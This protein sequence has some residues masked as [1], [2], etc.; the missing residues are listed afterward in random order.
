M[1]AFD[2]RLSGVDE[3]LDR[4]DVDPAL[5]RDVLAQL[6]RVNRWLGGTRAL[7]LEF[8]R[9]LRLIDRSDIRLL[10]VGCGVGDLPAAL[11]EAGKDVGVKVDPVGVD[12]H[13][14]VLEVANRRGVRPVLGS[15]LRLPFADRSFDVVTA[16]MVLHHFEGEQLATVLRECCRVGRYA[17]IVNDLYRHP[18]A[19]A[20]WLAWSSLFVRGSVIRYDG[21]I[22]VRRGFREEDLWKLASLEERFRWQVKRRLGF[23]ICLVGI[24]ERLWGHRPGESSADRQGGAHT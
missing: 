9:V 17:V 12:L 8:L 6:P 22:S 1:S 24:R 11:V 7:R 18:L 13:R 3:I 23:R 4:R 5:R 19:W 20:G 2:K 14:E 10:D 21:A 16:S 15:G